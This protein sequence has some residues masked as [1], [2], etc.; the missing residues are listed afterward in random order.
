[1]SADVIKNRT[2]YMLCRTDGGTD[3]YIGSTSIPLGYRFSQHKYNAGNPSRLKWYGGS[4]LY[5]KMRGVGVHRWKM[6]PLLTFACDRATVCEFEQVWIEATGAN[7]N[8]ISSV[9]E[10]LDKREYDKQH[11]RNNIEEK[12]FYCE[13]CDVACKDNYN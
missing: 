5:K 1:M 2:V 9:N 7:L 13:L 12:R 10:E 4:K 11:R 8:T 6:V 3:I